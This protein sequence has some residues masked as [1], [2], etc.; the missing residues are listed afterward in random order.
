MILA[1]SFNNWDE[2]KVRLSKTAGG[3]EVPVF[4]SNGTYTY[5]YIVDGRWMI[6]PANPEKT[7]NEFDDY[8][9]V[10]SVGKPTVFI[11]DGLHDAKKVFL[12]GSF[13]NWREFE[14]PMKKTATGWQIPYVLSA[15][16]YEYKF[17]VDGVWID[18]EGNETGKDRGGSLLVIDPNY[19]FRLKKFPDAKF[20][21]V[22]GDFNGWQPHAGRMKKEGDEWVL[23]MHLS[24]GK[25]L[26]KFVV[27]G[28]WIKDPDNELW[29]ENEFNTG[30]SIMWF[31]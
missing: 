24:P 9:S 15:G 6:D 31:R 30:N 3:W 27:D 18:A 11:L 22:A 19:T 14:L 7:P 28:K 5:R 26:Y 12:T 10:I 25:H 23:K 20:V 2:G 29:E 17:I 4:L 16:N 8:N 13:N 1:G 21:F